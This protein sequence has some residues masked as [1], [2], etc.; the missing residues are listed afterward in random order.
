MAFVGLQRS[1]SPNATRP[2]PEQP[3][4]LC[5]SVDFSP[6]GKIAATGSAS[7]TVQLW[8]L[9]DPSHP[10]LL[11]PPLNAHRGQVRGVAFANKETLVTVGEDA[12]VRVWDIANP[13]HPAPLGPPL[14]GHRR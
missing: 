3:R 9:A 11:G 7:K 13:I 5:D 8:N 6:D 10:S 1:Q 12:A 4:P 2:T 14:K